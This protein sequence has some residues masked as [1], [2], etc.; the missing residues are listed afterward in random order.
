MVPAPVDIGFDLNG[1]ID[2]ITEHEARQHVVGPAG[3]SGN[4]ERGIRDQPSDSQVV[5]VAWG[6]DS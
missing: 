6:G 2:Q 5:C 3:E 1:V 4:N